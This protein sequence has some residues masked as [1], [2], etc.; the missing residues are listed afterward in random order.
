MTTNQADDLTAETPKPRQVEERPQKTA[1]KAKPKTTA[2]A[3]NTA[4]PAAGKTAAQSQP[5][6]SAKKLQGTTRPDGKASSQAKAGTSSAAAAKPTARTSSRGTVKGARECVKEVSTDEAESLPTSQSL[7]EKPAQNLASKP[8]RKSVRKPEP[9]PTVQT[10]EPST[11]FSSAKPVDRPSNASKA[12]DAKNPDD[13]MGLHDRTTASG[14]P[15]EG[16][17]PNENSVPPLNPLVPPAEGEASSRLSEPSEGSV[18][19]VQPLSASTDAPSV[20]SADEAADSTSI[21]SLNKEASGE[22][23]VRPKD[24][25]SAESTADPAESGPVEK[26]VPAQDSR[27]ALTRAVEKTAASSE[28][29]ARKAKT[30]PRSGAKAASQTRPTI[31][32]KSKSSAKHS[33]L[34]SESA[35]AKKSG[36]SSQTVKFTVGEPVARPAE[37]KTKLRRGRPSLATVFA[38]ASV[39][40]VDGVTLKPAVRPAV[41]DT[42]SDQDSSSKTPNRA[43]SE[44]PVREAAGKAPTEVETPTVVALF[45]EDEE[46]LIAEE[47]TPGNDDFSKNPSAAPAAESLLSSTDADSNEAE[48]DKADGEASADAKTRKPPVAERLTGRRARLPQSAPRREASGESLLS[49]PTQGT[50][51]FA[52]IMRK[53]LEEVRKPVVPIA[54]SDMTEELALERRRVVREAEVEAIL[55][56]ILEESETHKEAH[57]KFNALLNELAAPVPIG[58][59]RFAITDPEGFRRSILMSKILLL[60]DLR[61]GPSWMRTVALAREKQGLPLRLSEDLTFY[62]DGTHAPEDEANGM[63]LDPS[64]AVVEATGQ[65]PRRPNPAV[66]H[67]LRQG[68]APSPHPPSPD[69]RAPRADGRGSPDCPRGHDGCP[70]CGSADGC[71]SPDAAPPSNLPRHRPDRFA[72]GD[73]WDH[74]VRMLQICLC[75]GLLFLGGM[76]GGRMTAR[77]PGVLHVERMAF[78]DLGAVARSGFQDVE[79]FEEAFRDVLDDLSRERR[80]VLVAKNFLLTGPG[81]ESP[82]ND[83]TIEVLAGL[84]DRLG[85]PGAKGRLSPTKSLPTEFTSAFTPASTDDANDLRETQGTFQNILDQGRGRNVLHLPYSSRLPP[86]AARTL[87]ATEHAARASRLKALEAEKSALDASRAA[88]DLRAALRRAEEDE[89][90]RRKAGGRP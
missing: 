68:D 60:P 72:A 42:A 24:S 74:L 23:L 89:A 33:A 34:S 18:H 4:K 56:K 35:S 37:K 87:Y 76:I 25:D 11:A 26:K 49:A 90:L 1:A 14:E 30:G 27:D 36:T 31:T 88:E 45:S 57:A 80:A 20:A 52:K 78:V 41:P 58:P 13:P 86:D 61:S 85:V 83:V 79:G 43:E 47:L 48:P 75:L 16:P 28:K 50:T 6:G 71:S 2:K 59:S 51:P 8:S 77:D 55:T 69:G 17:L 19:P 62:L 54:P 40:A 84:V 70:A 32:A 22:A 67:F 5:K 63:R 39:D 64:G 82:D 53:A 9:K 38:I 15:L 29:G 3:G 12:S 21:E 73:R 46:A 81:P 44:A 65:P 7:A 66:T 10:S